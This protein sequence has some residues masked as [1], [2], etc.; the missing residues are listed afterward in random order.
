MSSATQFLF[1]IYGIVIRTLQSHDLHAHSVAAF[2]VLANVWLYSMALVIP[3]GAIGAVDLWIEAGRE[4]RARSHSSPCCAFSCAAKSGPIQPPSHPRSAGVS[5]SH[6][7]RTSF[8]LMCVLAIAVFGV[9]VKLL[10]LPGVN[11]LGRPRASASPA[12]STRLA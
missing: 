11:A 5:W 12:P 6:D 10:S 8:T 1:G 4:L 7:G 9:T 3:A 2:L